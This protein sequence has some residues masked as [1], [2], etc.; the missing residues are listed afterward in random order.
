MVRLTA[1][2]PNASALPFWLKAVSHLAPLDILAL[3]QAHVFKRQIDGNFCHLCAT[4]IECTDTLCLPY[5]LDPGGVGY[6]HGVFPSLSLYTLRVKIS[7]R[8]Y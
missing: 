8:P 7:C 6:T 3:P 5:D 2:G 1:V 4:E